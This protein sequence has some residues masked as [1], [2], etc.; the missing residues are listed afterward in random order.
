MNKKN[1]I[2]VFCFKS[3]LF[4]LTAFIGITGTLKRLEVSQRPVVAPISIESFLVQF[5]IL[6][7]LILLLVKFFKKGKKKRYVFDFLFI[8][9]VFLGGFSVL[10]LWLPDLYSFIV[11]ALL[12]LV[13]KKTK[14]I[15]IHNLCMVL[16]LGGVVSFSAFNFTPY[17]VLLL[18]VLFSVYDFIAVYKTKHMVKM[19]ESM[20][21]TGSILGFIIP[22]R[23]DDFKRK[24][25][26]FSKGW[27]FVF[28]GGDIAFPLL[29]ICSLIPYGLRG[30]LFV[31][32]FSFLGILF[33][34]FI[35]VLQKEK[36]AIPALPPIALFS[37]IGYLVIFLTM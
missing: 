15:I 19:A 29:L 28:G 37:I 20:I 35:F 3:F 25:S 2:Q 18:L 27:A 5:L 8:L 21:E 6:T 9:P 12:I 36:R 26:N 7:V 33:S 10:N 30:S 13:W 34:F 16:G 23:F 32:T 14:N 4:F 24:A 1:I 31:M 22:Y 11:I 17:Q